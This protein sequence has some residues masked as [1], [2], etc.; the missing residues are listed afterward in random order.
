VA[1]DAL[2]EAGRKQDLIHQVRTDAA[3]IAH[4]IPI[5]TAK[6]PAERDTA[7][8]A[9]L[10]KRMLDLNARMDTLTESLSRATRL[11]D[12]AVGARA[13]VGLDVLTLRNLGGTRSSLLLGWLTGDAATPQTLDQ[14]SDLTSRISQAWETLQHDVTALG[15]PPA[16]RQA[17]ETTNQDFFVAKEPGFR[18]IIAAARA[19]AARPE[20]VAQYRADSVP[21]LAA[22]MV[23]R[24]AAIGDAVALGRE[25]AAYGLRGVV[26]S[27]VL[28]AVTIILCIAG[29]IL[30]LRRFVQP[31]QRLTATVAGIAEGRLDTEVPYGERRDELGALAKAVTVLRERSREARALNEAAQASTE[32]KLRRAQEVSTLVQDFE[33]GSQAAVAAVEEAAASLHEV[34]GALRAASSSSAEQAGTIADN[35]HLANA[36]VNNLAAATEELSSSIGEIARRITE[37]ARSV[38]EAAAEARGSAQQIEALAEA[39]ARIGD[40]VQLIEGIAG[41]TNLLALNATIEAARAGDAGKGFAVVAQEVKGLAAQTARATGEVASQIGILQSRTGD[42]VEAIRRVAG[43]VDGV[44]SLTSG[45]AAAVEQQRAATAEIAR[46]VQEAAS[47]TSGVTGG[48]E[49]VRAG[50][51]ET[52]SSASGLFGVAEQ[53]RADIEGLQSRITTF[54]SGVRQAA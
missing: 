22:L 35:A 11:A 27:F 44:T 5:M 1:A 47:A 37:V 12:P 10:V 13:S 41:Q 18:A 31:T 21:A 36:S 54:I 2:A 3:D 43:T 32:Q 14:M 9:S 8:R 26:I 24:D 53:V 29:T 20:T 45:I 46:S 19:G 34:A 25:E 42:A 48:I 52:D 6:P 38:D 17:I 4:Q 50:T 51:A 15:N 28:L 49:Q 33:A 7:A 40:V 30:S 39:G 16:L 23:G